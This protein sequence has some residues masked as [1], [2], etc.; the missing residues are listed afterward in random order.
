MR[1]DVLWNNLLHNIFISI[2]IFLISICILVYHKSVY[3]VKNIE[4]CIVSSASRKLPINLVKYPRFLKQ[5]A[6]FVRPGEH[7][8]QLRNEE[9]YLSLPSSQHHNE[10]RLIRVITWNI[11]RGLEL[12]KIITEL[13]LLDADI[14]LLQEVDAY[15]ER[16]GGVDIAQCI[17]E[18]LDMHFAWACEFEEIP[19]KRR[20]KYPNLRVGSG[21]GHMHG[22]AI[23][24][25]REYSFISTWSFLHKTQPFNWTTH[26]DAVFKEPRLGGRIC[27]GALVRIPSNKRSNSHNRKGKKINS[28]LTNMATE[29][30]SIEEI[31]VYNL[32]LENNASIAERWEQFREVCKDALHRRRAYSSQLLRYSPLPMIL[33]GDLN[34]LSSGIAK[35]L[36]RFWEWIVV[37]SHEAEYWQRVLLPSLC[38]PPDHQQQEELMPLHLQD[39]FPKDHVGATVRHVCGLYAA[40]LDWLLIEDNKRV[41]NAV[42]CASGGGKISDHLWLST[43]LLL[44]PTEPNQ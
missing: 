30:Q 4:K 36:P 27:L 6:S 32:H 41:W 34:T 26:G 40:K 31:M 15:C 11:E 37:W 35:L 20:E 24:I 9:N 14:L 13:R 8:V 22:N 28:I 33:G 18:A 42:A 43:D 23:L 5:A 39:K 1:I 19:S 2:C 25:R 38:S 29:E 10:K 17:A 16:S 7:R 44:Q 12:E 21:T 3:F